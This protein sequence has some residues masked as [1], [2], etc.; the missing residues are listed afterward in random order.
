MKYIIN[1]N[2]SKFSVN[3]L[4]LFNV[5]SR[6][7]V[8]HKYGLAHYFEHLLFNGTKKYPTSKSISDRIYKYGGETNAF[9]SYDITGYYITI[10]YK[11]TEIALDILSD[12]LF[13]SI[14]TDYIKEKDVVINENIKFR[15]NPRTYCRS[16]FENMIYKNTPFEHDVIGLNKDIKKFTKKDILDFYKKYYNPNN[17]I[18]SVCGKINKNTEKYIKKYFNKKNN[19]QIHYPL[20]NNFMDIQQKIRFKSYKKNVEQAQIYMG[21]PAY[22]INNNF[23]KYVLE[24]ISNV[25]AGNMSSRLFIKLRQQKGLVYTV[26]SNLDFYEDIGIIYIYFGTF[27]KSVKQAVNIVINEIK[28][29]K[30]N[31]LT[32]NE[33]NENIK[34]IIGYQE[35][36]SENNENYNID[37]AYDALFDNK[38]ISIKKKNKIF[39]KIKNK[40]IINVANEIFNLNK[41]NICI[42]SNKKYNNFIKI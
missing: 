20:Y 10:N 38:N 21:F 15:T 1:N 27:N 13:N 4:L 16:Q 6:H 33:I 23:N 29:I 18:L 31:G 26:S 42:V 34:Y 40:D 25:L 5:G 7:E 37:I 3:I 8:K 22:C 11:Y 19:N 36:D 39:N 9:T 24:L 41:L 2:K 32:K 12:M 35:M 28:N 30:K 17:C 14:F